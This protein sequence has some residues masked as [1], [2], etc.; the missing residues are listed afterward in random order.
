MRV[1][2]SGSQSLLTSA[3]TMLVVEAPANISL[4]CRKGASIPNLP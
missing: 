4:P 1:K 2:L 3:A